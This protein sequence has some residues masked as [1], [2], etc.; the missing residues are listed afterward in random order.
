LQSRSWRTTTD[1]IFIGELRYET[2]TLA[3]TIKHV[4]WP[5]EM[6]IFSSWRALFKNVGLGRVGVGGT[7]GRT[8]GTNGG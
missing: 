4:G 6:A 7:D 5:T 8:K 2:M 3:T 1:A